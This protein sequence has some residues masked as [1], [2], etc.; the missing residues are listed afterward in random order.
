MR[1]CTF[2]SYL[3]MFLRIYLRFRPRDLLYKIWVLH[4]LVEKN[5]VLWVEVQDVT[6]VGLFC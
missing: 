4:L 3:A 2:W 6:G 5:P 1:E